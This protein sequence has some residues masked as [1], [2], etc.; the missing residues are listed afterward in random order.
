MDFF[1][2][3]LKDIIWKGL[4][5]NK[6]KLECFFYIMYLEEFKKDE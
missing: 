5:K 4:Y 2:F 3:F 6:D 1:F